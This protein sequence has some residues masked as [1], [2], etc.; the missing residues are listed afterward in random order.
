MKIKDKENTYIV[1]ISSYPPRE[2]GIATFT[3]DITAAFDNKFNP[4]VKSRIIALN[5]NPT[6]IYNYN[7]K[8]I[9]KEIN[10]NEISYYVSLAK[11]LNERND[12]KIINIQHEFGLFGGNW[13]DYIIPFIQVIEKPVIITFHSVLENPDEELLSVVKAIAEKAVALVV[14]NK[15]SKNVLLSDYRVPASK[16]VIIP[17]GIPQTSLE[18]SEKFKSELGLGHK[19]VLSTFGFLS[20]KTI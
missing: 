10:V 15:L 12:V 1:H 7:S 5:E 3:Q 14:M 6:R 16:V 13:G 19:I 17:H 8:K 4:A 2:C 9:L 20:S 18:A 11:E